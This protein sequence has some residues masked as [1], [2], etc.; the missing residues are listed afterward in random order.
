MASVID[1]AVRTLRALDSVVFDAGDDAIAVPPASA[2]GFAVRLQMVH[3]REYVVSYEGWQHTFDRAEDAYDCFEYGLSDSCR[4]KIALRGDE[5][6]GWH[7]EKWEYGMWVPAQ[8]P[9]RRRSLAFWRPLRTV[10][11]QNHVF[12]RSV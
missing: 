1:R 7:V 12:R 6:V 8:H 5:P 10:Y 3:D 4:L 2:D 11:R 9:R